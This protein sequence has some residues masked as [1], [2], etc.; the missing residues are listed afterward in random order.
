K[1]AFGRAAGGLRILLPRSRAALGNSCV[2]PRAD[3][4]RSVSKRIHRR[5]ATT[6]APG[7]STTGSL[8]EDRQYARS[9]SKRARHGRGVSRFQDRRWRND[10]SGVSNAGPSDAL[11]SLRTKLGKSVILV[12]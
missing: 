11:W 10:R 6:L 1:R 9:N 5:R 2:D 7:W 8:Y 12:A 4:L 3:C